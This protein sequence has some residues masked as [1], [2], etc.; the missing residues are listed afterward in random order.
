MIIIVGI[1]AFKQSIYLIVF[2]ITSTLQ[3][4]TVQGYQN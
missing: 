4:S 1:E 3:S 2:K